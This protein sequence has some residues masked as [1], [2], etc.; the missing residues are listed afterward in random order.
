[1]A[2]LAL[3]QNLFQTLPMSS[4][5]DTEYDE[6]FSLAIK[7][8]M[9]GGIP[10]PDTELDTVNSDMEDEIEVKIAAFITN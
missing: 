5:T 9:T 7:R 10:S 1:M 6:I 3:T 8:G 4:L 2:L